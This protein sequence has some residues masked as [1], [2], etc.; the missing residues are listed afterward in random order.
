MSTEV[1]T[2]DAADSEAPAVPSVSSTP[3]PEEPAPWRRRR[4]QVIAGAVAIA[5]IVVLVANNFL[6]RQYSPA[7]AVS[8]YLSAI[9]SGDAAAA[10]SLIQVSGPTTRVDANLTD[11]AALQAALG[12][13]KPDMKSFAITGTINANASLAAVNFSYETSGGT[14]QGTLSVERSGQTSFG[15]YPVWHVVITPAV[16]HVAVPQGGSG[17]SI[18]GK[19]I[20]LASGSKAAV[21]VLPLAHKVRFNGSQMLEGQ[22]VAIDAFP[23]SEQTVAYQPTLTAAGFAAAKA[24]IKSAFDACARSTSF[25][26]DGCPQKYDAYFVSSPQWQLVGDPLQ[27][28]TISF[29]QDL[30]ASGAGH[31]QMEIAYQE[32]G[33]PG[34]HHDISSGGYSAHLL[35]AATSVAVGSIST[36]DGL[37][38]LQRPAGATDQTAKDLVS[39]ALTQCAG[40]QL[41]TPP[42]CP[43][44]IVAA[45]VSNVRWTLSGDPLASATVTFDQK[46][47]VFTVHGRFAM[48]ASYDWLGNAESASSFYPAYDALLCW[49][50]QALVLVT[51][52]GADS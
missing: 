38:G 23:S 42:D 30:N 20:A 15:F 11:R 51:I 39:K 9:R 3:R 41:Q 12:S 29:D 26:Q 35:F 25:T 8:Q 36:A 7:G 5:L 45:S 16:L 10:W 33:S 40:L 32:A 47:G 13:G 24:A 28:V 44:R 37:P 1:Q 19:A 6:A 43:Q 50:G 14:K 4:Y 52:Q 34:T 2:N 46:S 21:A 27:D 48:S 49:D 22:T 17:F 18:D 31:Y